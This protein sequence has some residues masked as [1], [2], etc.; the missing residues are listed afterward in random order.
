MQVP[1]AAFST[2]GYCS[3]CGSWLGKS[4]ID[5]P[6]SGGKDDLTSASKQIASIIEILPKIDPA[7]VAMS[8]RRNINAYCEQVASGDFLTLAR[9]MRCEHKT[10]RSWLE[11][12][13]VLRLGKLVQVAMSLDV[14]A[15]S[16]L[17]ATPPSSADVERARQ[18]VAL[19]RRPFI[20]LPH[21]IIEIR[22][23]LLAAVDDEVAPALSE[24]ARRLGF[25]GT[26]KLYYADR[27]LC[28]QIVQRHLEVAPGRR[29]IT[30]SPALIK[31]TL[32]RALESSAP[33]ALEQIARDLG[34]AGSGSL[35]SKFPDLCAAISKK[36]VDNT[37]L[38]YAKVSH[39]LEDALKK[40][41]APTLAAV[42]RSLGCASNTLQTHESELSSQ[43]LAL[44]RT[45][46]EERKKA[47][48][49][50]AEAALTEV[51]P[52]SVRQLCIRLGVNAMTMLGYCPSA[53][54]QLAEQ[55]RLYIANETTRR[56]EALV[57]SVLGIATDLAGRNIYPSLPRIVE[58][59]PDGHV[60]DWRFTRRVVLETQRMLAS[61]AG[62]FQSG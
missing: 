26:Y 56:Q 43:L 31:E 54:K 16:F 52:P 17:T 46:L 36:V 32:T 41:P 23:A 13:A 6:E 58:R 18:A 28:R 20:S 33:K 11:G 29:K 30:V 49:K 51:P 35:R 12:S 22:Q 4:G 19:D 34:Y 10:L 37:Q 3:L 55:H 44:H 61:S 25:K 48:V 24:V 40:N 15:S 50:E 45:Q 5:I 38:H 59:L 21:Q 60:S 14:P 8:L 2:P 39:A 57:S 9:Y 1:L 7:T 27:A 53:M 47:L 42:A 62:S